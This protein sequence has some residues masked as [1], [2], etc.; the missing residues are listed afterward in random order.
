MKYCLLQ[1]STLILPDLKLLLLTSVVLLPPDGWCDPVVFPTVVPVWFLFLDHICH[2]WQETDRE[3]EGADV[4]LGIPSHAVCCAG[5][6][7]L[8]FS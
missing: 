7:F 6:G 2:G 4:T 3:M 1:N 8:V 5:Q